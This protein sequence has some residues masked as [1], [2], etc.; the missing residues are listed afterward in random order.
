MGRKEADAFR[1]Q[2]E[3]YG[4]RHAPRLSHE[5]AS[6]NSFSSNNADD[7][8]QEGLEWGE[9]SGVEHAVEAIVTVFIENHN[10]SLDNFPADSL[11]T[12]LENLLLSE[13]SEEKIS[14]IAE[15]PYDFGNLS[16]L[17]EKGVEYGKIFGHNL[18]VN[19]ALSLF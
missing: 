10:E 1:Q 19:Y 17:F 12:I 11:R 4:F 18:T 3:T 14:A 6:E 8:F 15:A 7:N 5:E 9:G 2:I 16:D 13:P